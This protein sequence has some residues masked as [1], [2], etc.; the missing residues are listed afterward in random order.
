[1]TNP[2]I[3]K[4]GTKSWFN[5]KGELHRDD[6]PAVEWADG[7]KEWYQNG[8]WHREDGPAVEWHNGSKWWILKGNRIK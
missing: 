8:L 4:T 1:M 6:G 5:A 7:D 2:I 3:S